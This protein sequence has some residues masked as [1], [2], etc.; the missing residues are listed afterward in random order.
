MGHVVLAAKIT[1]VP[2]IW[3]SEH[4][5]AHRGIR[6]NAIDGLREIGRRARA[7]GADTF[8]V[9][10]VHWLVNQGFHLNANAHH[11][12][13]FTSHELPHFLSA[14]DYDFP[15]DPELARH[16]EA[17]GRDAG[18]G[19]RAHAVDGL[20]ME[21]GTLIPMHH[22][23]AD[24]ALRVLSSAANQYASIDEGRRFGEVVAKAIAASPRKVAVL[25]SGSL[26]HQFWPNA[27]SVAGLDAVNTEFN[28]Q[29][30]LHVLDLWRQGR[31]KEFLA[32][33][34][35]YA[36]RCHGEANMIDTAH[37]FGVLGWDTYA[38]RGT[39]LGEYFG[40]SGT[41]QCNVVFEV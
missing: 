31:I 10:D 5:E 34:P 16:I 15:G 6:Q 20:G 17:A 12:G 37:L 32:M 30:D 41:G 39:V 35:E 36:A 8:L 18:L 40:S 3:L 28:R 26:S 1:H 25:A 11:R 4:S 14:L 13:R 38:G 29:V 23:N 27:Q 33:L 7:A 21:Y 9:F 22:M 24:G 19:V 2:S